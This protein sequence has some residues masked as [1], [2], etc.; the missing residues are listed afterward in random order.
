MDYEG[1][2]CLVINTLLIAIKVTTIGKNP[3]TGIAVIPRSAIV[4]NTAL[5][6]VPIPVPSTIIM[7]S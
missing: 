2:K 6:T 5:T 7:N 3:I 4:I 1:V